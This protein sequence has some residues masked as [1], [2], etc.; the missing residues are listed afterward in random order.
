MPVSFDNI[1]F[2]QTYTRNQLAER[3]GYAGRQPLERGVVTPKG[4]PFIILFITEAKQKHFIQYKDIFEGG[5]LEI[6]GATKHGRDERII[7]ADKSGDEIHLF[8]RATPYA[9]FTYEGRVY[10]EWYKRNISRPSRF[11]FSTKSLQQNV[12]D[13]IA[14]EKAT[15]GVDGNPSLRMHVV[16][17]RDARKREEAIRIHGKNCLACGFDFNAFYG[18][19]FARGFIEVHHKKS[20]TKQAG[21]GLDPVNDLVPLCS[22]CHSMAHRRQGEILSLEDLRKLILGN[23]RKLVSSS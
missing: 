5:I 2:K 1:K 16:Y 8:H 15:R 21:K 13:D 18:A 23:N 19:D 22:N 10:L 12:L 17:E 3:W 9:R 14:T 20:I 4:T 7:N 6:E 11:R